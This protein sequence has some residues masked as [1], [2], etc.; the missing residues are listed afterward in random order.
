MRRGRQ[1]VDHLSLDLLEKRVVECVDRKDRVE[2][3]F[4]SL[5]RTGNRRKREIDDG[6]APV[7]SYDRFAVKIRG[8]DLEVSAEFLLRV[9]KSGRAGRILGR[10]RS[11]AEHF[12]HSGARVEDRVGMKLLISVPEA[13]DPLF[14]KCLIHKERQIFSVIVI[15]LRIGVRA[16]DP[17][18]TLM[19]RMEKRGNFRGDNSGQS[20]LP[21]V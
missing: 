6:K 7:F 3:L 19:E 13:F 10:K 8:P 12:D 20:H 14:V 9:T 21:E 15:V 1:R 16:A 17:H 2:D 4:K 18:G 11:R 5:S